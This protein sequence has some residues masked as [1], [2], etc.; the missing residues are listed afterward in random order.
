MCRLKGP[1][2]QLCSCARVLFETGVGQP[3]TCSAAPQKPWV[4]CFTWL[5]VKPPRSDVVPLTHTF[6]PVQALSHIRGAWP[7]ASPNEGFV[8]QL[9]LFED[10]RC[11]LDTEHPVYRLWCL[12][13]VGRTVVHTYFTLALHTQPRA[14]AHTHMAECPACEWR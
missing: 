5:Q 10:M 14:H 13:Q 9:G 7:S 4:T 6:C 12:Q 2:W 8:A 3:Q 1:D 11:S